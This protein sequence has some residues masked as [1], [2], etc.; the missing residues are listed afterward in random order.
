MES[1]KRYFNGQASCY[2]PLT[3]G[4]QVRSCCPRFTAILYLDN[5]HTIILSHRPTHPPDKHIAASR[6]TTDSRQSRHT[7]A[8]RCSHTVADHMFTHRIHTTTIIT[9]PC[10]ANCN[11]LNRSS[12]YFL[13]TLDYTPSYFVLD[14]GW[15]NFVTDQDLYSFTAGTDP[16]R[17]ATDFVLANFNSID[18]I[19]TSFVAHYR[20]VTSFR[21]KIA[22]NSV[23]SMSIANFKS[24]SAPSFLHLPFITTV[25]PII[26]VH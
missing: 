14:S 5:L 9:A 8:T 17:F 23:H 21:C 25:D 1:S 19:R 18:L 2:T 10:W 4:L 26:A 15:S 22:A 3:W 6:N 20:F 12:S 16:P 13:S 7:V 11:S 24:K